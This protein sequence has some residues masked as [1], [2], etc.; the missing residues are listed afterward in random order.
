MK[1][2]AR[3]WIVGSIAGVSLA[4]AAGPAAAADVTDND[5]TFR[6]FTRET[7]TVGDGRI[8]LEIRGLQAQ[9]E[10]NTRLN[11]YG[12]LL[13]K[14]QTQEVTGGVVDLLASYG[15]GK[16][17]ELGFDIPSYIESKKFVPG[18]NIHNRVT[19]EDVGDIMLYAKFR[20]SVAE[21]CTAGA[22]LELTLPN[23]PVQKGFS[24][25]ELGFNPY[26]STRYQ[27]GPVAL[28]TNIGY[29]MYT[30]DQKDPQRTFEDG[31]PILLSDQFNYGVEAIVRGSETYA[32]RAELAGR[33]FNLRGQRF[34]DAVLLPGIDF[35]LAQNFVIRPTGL[36]NI[37]ATAL[38]WGLG[39]GMAYTF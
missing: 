12:L 24:T 11:L 22:G 30:G 20:R 6:N 38:D 23:G 7:A 8:R 28:G 27:R 29:Q 34:H 18:T 4:V 37:T 31:Q 14:G 2:A 17:A 39:V 3:R 10:E 16:N 21:H 32:L 33:V 25:G 26:V 1:R 19:N 35:N 5:R 13:P 15:L 36:A 9:D